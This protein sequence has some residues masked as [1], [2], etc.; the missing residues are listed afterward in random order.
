VAE[1]ARRIVSGETS[2]PIRTA[3]DSIATLVVMD[4]IRRQLGVVFDGEPPDH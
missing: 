3:A 4:E 2:S 1:T